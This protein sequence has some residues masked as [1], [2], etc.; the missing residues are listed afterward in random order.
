MGLDWL[1][2]DNEKK[3]HQ[4]FEDQFFGTE[5][6]STGYEKKPLKNPETGEAVDGLY[7]AWITLNNP[8]Q[9][10]SYTTQMVKGVIAGMHRASMERDVMAIVFTAAGENLWFE[11]SYV[12][13]WAASSYAEM[14]D[15]SRLIFGT[16]SPRNHL[17]Y[18]LQQFGKHL[19]IAQYPDVYGGNLAR[20]LEEVLR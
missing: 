18:E 4:L 17:G 11:L 3:D 10:N 16:S 19:P 13:P 9:L 5:P 15:R 12:R 8:A 20:L 6:P 14:V 1:I 7:S 2:R